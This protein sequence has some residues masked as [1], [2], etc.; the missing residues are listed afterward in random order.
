MR[1]YQLP[2]SREP[3]LLAIEYGLLI[4]CLLPLLAGRYTRWYFISVHST[5]GHIVLWKY[6]LFSQGQRGFVISSSSF[7]GNFVGAHGTGGALAT[8]NSDIVMTSV[9]ITNNTA[10]RGGGIAV[11]PQSTLTLHRYVL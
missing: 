9:N 6:F 10:Y 3:S 11:M 5:L 7:D 1:K 8:S 4:H 2:R